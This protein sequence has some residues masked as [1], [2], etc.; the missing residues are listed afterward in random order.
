MKTNNLCYLPLLVFSLFTGGL[1]A[2]SQISGTVTDTAGDVLPGVS[3]VLKGTVTGVTTNFDGQYTISVPDAQSILV[4]SYLGMSSKEIAVGNRSNIDVVLEASSQELDEVVVTALGISREKK[5]L[6]YSVSEVGG[7]AIDN[8]PQENALNALSGKVSGV[9]INSTGTPGSSVSMVIRGSTSL[10]GD[11]QPLFVVDGVPIFNTLNNVGGVGRDNRVDYGNAI[12]DINTD[13]IESMTVLKGASAAALYGSRAGNGVV[14]ITTKSGKSRKGL[15]VTVNSSTVFDIPYRYLD[16]HSRF[17]AGSR[18]YTPD[19]FPTNPYGEILISETA[20]AWAGPALDQGIKAIHWPYTAQELESGNPVA[21]ELRSHNNP[22]NFFNTAIT[23]TNNISVQDNTE[24]VNYRL[25]YNHLKNKGFI[26]NT[27]LNKHSINLN[28]KINLNQNVSVSSSLNYTKTY[29]D[30]RPAGN[31]GANPIQ[32]MYEIAPHIDVRDLK[33]YWLPGFEGLF[34]NSPFEFG[35]DPTETEWNNPYFLANEVNNGF[36]RNRFYGNIRADYKITD[37]FSAMLRY[38]YDE[39]NE[40]RETKI[41]NGYTNEM[42]GAYGLT[43]IF[44]KEINVDFLL[45]YEKNFTDWDFSVSFGGNQRKFD[46][47]TVRNATK[48]RGQGLLT[49]NLFTLSNIAPNNLDFDSYKQE[50]KVNSLYGLASIGFKDMFYLD[51]TGRNDWSSTLPDS[52]NS[53]FYPSI[54]GSLLLN[55]AFDMGNK[56]SLI[57]LRAGYAE[58]GNDTDPYNLIPVLNSGGSW[59]DAS[60]LSVPGDLLNTG[61][62]PESQNSWEV[63]VDMAFLG[64]RLR[65]DATYYESDN[66]DQIFPVNN[67]IS[68]GYDTKFINAGLLTSE[69]V[70]ASLGGTLVTNRDWN[71]DMDFVF[72]RNRTTVVKLAEDMNSITL[73]TDAKGGAITWLGEE[74][75]NIVDRELVRV[76]DLNSPYH[77]WP[78]ID[79]EGFENSDRTLEDEDGNRVAPIIG[80]FNPD[81][82]LGMTTS[83]SYK[84]LSLSMNLDWRKGGQFVSQTHRYGESDMHTQRWL[85]KLHNL[86]DVG[87]IPTY[88]KENENQYLSEDGEFYVLVG[89]PT[90]EDG[91]FPVDDGG[92]TLSDGVFMPG[93]QGEYDDDGNFVATSENLGGPGT[94]YTRY[95]DHYGWDFTRNATFDSDF[96]KLREI[97]LSY[98][99]SS[100]N[101]Q[102]IG[103]QNMTISLFSRNV[104]LWTKADIG[105][106]PEMA[107]QPESDVQGRSG[108]QFK[109]GIERFNVNPFAIPVGFKLNFSF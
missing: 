21:R 12:S 65:L 39:I 10:S 1:F 98:A 96:V 28:S 77:G 19:N 55:N 94:V 56:V 106:D 16:T 95:Q 42:N 52:N 109:Q 31:R 32:A 102:Q 104:I 59:G 4:F 83:V 49:P 57:K 107:F 27:D 15:G 23:T 45:T 73:W 63:G 87:D 14:L 97:S 7:D 51:V 20:S 6:G 18:P 26:P 33:Q 36:V 24:K 34:Q 101:L 50:K 80:N 72:T 38:N 99:L 69:G 86:N 9:A 84:N 48:S 92:I 54:S 90:A 103:I 85:D 11:N 46:A 66:R 8:V 29:A 88:I 91:G 44:R 70:E 58:V 41:S 30:N 17:A 64:S 105:I 47:T 43:D 79:D 108:I 67:P 74:I 3:V 22:K 35:D 5:S 13:D 2:Q 60:L 62:K 71:W 75:G 78:L 82:I 37:D 68:S 81:F 76:E 100:K 61:L 53:Y 89:G 25:S 40:Q 93:V